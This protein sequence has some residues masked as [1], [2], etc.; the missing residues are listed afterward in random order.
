MLCSGARWVKPW[1]KTQAPIAF[2]SA[3][4]DLHAEAGATA[5]RLG[6]QSVAE[7]SG[8]NLEAR[9]VRHVS[10][11]LGIISRKGLGKAKR[12]DTSHLCAQEVSAKRR[13]KFDKV[14]GT[15]DPADLRTNE[16]SASDIEKYIAMINAYC[17]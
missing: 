17:C 11:A 7:G 1:S 14:L 15:N 2:S 12:L 4:S 13:V 8:M 6:L 9:V 5:E 10:A 16:F 3:E